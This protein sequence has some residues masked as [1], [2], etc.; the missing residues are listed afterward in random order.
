MSVLN[1]FLVAAPVAV[2]SW[3]VTQE[4]ICREIRGWCKCHLHAKLAYL[5]GCYYC[6]SHWVALAC[7]LVLGGPVLHDD[8]RGWFV[9]WLVTVLV[10]NVYLTAYNI[11]RAV[12]RGVRAWADRQEVKP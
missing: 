11:L 10:A 6:F 1:L 8:A 12:L 5:S 7:V 4:E 2:I 9:S 3:T